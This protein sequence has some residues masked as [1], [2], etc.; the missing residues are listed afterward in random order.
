MKKESFNQQSFLKS[1]FSENQYEEKEV[2][3]FWL[4]QQIN[5]WSGRP[6]IAIYTQESFKKYKAFKENL[7]KKKNKFKKFQAVRGILSTKVKPQDNFYSGIGTNYSRG[8]EAQ[9]K[10]IESNKRRKA[11]KEFA[12]QNRHIKQIMKNA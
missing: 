8:S 11:A 10:E 5:G 9:R 7:P 1:F 12:W 6:I 2:N 3:G 4:V